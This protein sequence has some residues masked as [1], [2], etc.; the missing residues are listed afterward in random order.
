MESSMDRLNGQLCAILPWIQNDPHGR[1]PVAAQSP[2]LEAQ[3]N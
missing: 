3:G 2:T 1:E